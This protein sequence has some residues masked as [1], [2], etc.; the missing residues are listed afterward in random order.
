MAAATFGAALVR[1][2]STTTGVEEAARTFTAA[3]LT[4][5]SADLEASRRRVRPLVTEGFFRNYEATLEALAAVN[6]AAS[7]K[8]TEV[9]VDLQAGDRASA[10]VVTDSTAT[11]N[12]Q[13]RATTGSYLRLDMVRRDGA[14]KVDS[15]LE[16][17]AGRQAGGEAQPED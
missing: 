15:V 16:I 5:E 1:E 10:I 13:P 11:S 14:W 12:G 2:R 8:A 7:G 6:S 4:Y 9:F 3:L 17:A